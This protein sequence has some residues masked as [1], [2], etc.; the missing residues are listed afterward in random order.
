MVLKF[1]VVRSRPPRREPRLGGSSTPSPRPSSRGADPRLGSAYGT[2][3]SPRLWNSW[4]DP[5]TG[6]RTGYRTGWRRRA[7]PGGGSAGTCG[8]QVRLGDPAGPPGTR[9]CCR[10]SPLQLAPRT[11]QAPRGSR[12]PLTPSRE[13]PALGGL[14][15]LTLVAGTQDS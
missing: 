15:E 6:A 8:P 5:K 1:S 9:P 11:F 12:E 7:E 13:V 4:R 3:L 10:R 2:F 14:P